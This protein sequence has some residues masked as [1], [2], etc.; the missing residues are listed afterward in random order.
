MGCE[1]EK[2]NANST[3]LI[4]VI[5]GNRYR[6]TFYLIFDFCEHDLAGLLANPKVQ[7]TLG[8]IKNVM[9]QMLNGLYYIHSNKV[10]TYKILFS[11]LN[12]HLFCRSVILRH[13]AYLFCFYGGSDISSTNHGNSNDFPTL[14]K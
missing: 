12:F 4:S 6:S 3:L 11:T 8:E 13:A 2:I 14:S 5:S 7:F 1:K 9:R 10:S